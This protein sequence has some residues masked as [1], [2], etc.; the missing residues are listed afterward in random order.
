MVVKLYMFD[1]TI[2]KG[3]LKNL[4]FFIVYHIVL[5]ATGGNLTLKKYLTFI[6]KYVIIIGSYE[7]GGHFVRTIYNVYCGLH[8]NCSSSYI[9]VDSINVDE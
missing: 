4:P 7:G 6:L 1:Q 2:K 9:V 8:Y 3:R 5:I